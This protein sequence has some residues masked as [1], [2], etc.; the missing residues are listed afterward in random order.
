MEEQQNRPKPGPLRW[1]DTY[2]GF[3]IAFFSLLG[4]IFL[5]LYVASLAK[6]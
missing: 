5:A 1:W 4:L 6:A 2:L 3:P